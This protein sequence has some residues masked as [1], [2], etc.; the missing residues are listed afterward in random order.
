MID[1]SIAGLLPLDVSGA[2]NVILTFTNGSPSQTDNA[3]FVLSGVLTGNINV[4]FPNGKTKLFMVKN[5]TTG[6][7][8]L[9]IGA[10]NSGVPAG[11]V[12]VIP[13][14]ATGMF[15]SDGTNVDSAFPTTFISPKFTG[16]VTGPDGG[17]W[18]S[19]GLGNIAALGVGITANTNAEGEIFGNG[20]QTN[21]P[22]DSGNRGAMLRLTDNSNS[23]GAGGCLAFANVQS[24]AANSFGFA[25]IKGLLTDGSNKTSG[26]IAFCVRIASTNSNLT[27]VATA[28]VDGSF[29]IGSYAAQGAGSL[30][31]QNNISC[32]GAISAAGNIT[33]FVS[34]DRLKTKLGQILSPISKIQAITPF[35]YELNAKGRELTGD[36]DRHIGLSAQEVERIMPEVVVPAP[37]NPEYKTIRYAELVP[38]L[39]AA[40]K[41]Q[42]TQIDALRK[43]RW[44]HLK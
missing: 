31:V 38:L 35:Y 19:T 9:S 22:I 21:N 17:T 12:A 33:G 25:A 32:G 1:A 14:G 29:L 44:W 20:Q 10:N 15:Y 2:S 7:F 27:P 28:N 6:A 37:S 5:S 11:S 40:I 4:L 3:I 43:R 30:G 24:N 16:T 42:Q 41:E 13:Q 26:S 23:A 18:T 8:T 39:V 36:T 34:D